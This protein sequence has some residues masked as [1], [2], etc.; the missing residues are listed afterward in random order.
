[1]K[2]I[3]FI[4]SGTSSGGSF[5]S[6]FLL[7]KKLDRSRFK[8]VVV[9]LNENPFIE[10]LE[11]LGIKV[12]LIEDYLYSKNVLFLKRKIAA[13]LYKLQFVIPALSVVLD[14]LIHS[15][16]IRKILKIIKEEE[17]SLVHLNNQPNRDL[18]GA[19]AAKI[20]KLPCVNHIRSPQ[21]SFVIN[22]TKVKF[23]NNNSS[24]FI[25]AS[26]DVK[27][28]WEK[29]GLDS[30]KSHLIYNGIPQQVVNTVKLHEQ[31]SLP[32]STSFVISC[33][34]RFVHWKGQHTL[35]KAFSK[36]SEQNTNSHLL[37]IG[38]G[39]EKEKLK[40]LVKECGVSDKVTFTGYINNSLEV[41]EAS[42]L[43]VLPSQNDVCSRV[44]LEAMM[45]GTPIIAADSGGNPELIS[46]NNNG[47]LFKYG[48]INDLSNAITQI[49]SSS[50]KRLKFVE[51][52]KLIQSKKFST[53]V[54]V[55]SIEMIYKDLFD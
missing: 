3:L 45:V 16:S 44:L 11:R 21:H 30:K 15:N 39:E 35:I 6:L 8:P 7:V 43:L 4:E 26:D 22:K 37:L 28:K 40:A 46:H 38:D 50:T 33:I 32:E 18:Y 20:A 54:Y 29:A 5:G 51:N 52:G 41:T 24:A 27:L 55:S 48:D 23:L 2:T 9:Y 31:F 19:L 12:Y 34:G 10:K 1:M 47:L 13:Q 17:I 53:E 36:F 25:A 14:Y 49:H 42:D